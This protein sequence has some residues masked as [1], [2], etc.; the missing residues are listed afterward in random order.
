[1]MMRSISLATLGA[2]PFILISVISLII[3]VSWGPTKYHHTPSQVLRSVQPNPEVAKLWNDYSREWTTGTKPTSAHD[4]HSCSRTCVCT[5]GGLM[6][7]GRFCGFGY[8]GCDGVVPCDGVDACCQIHDAC[9]GSHG[10][11]DCNCTTA[12]TDCLACAMY[13]DES[14]RCD[15]RETAALNMMADIKFIVSKCYPKP[16]K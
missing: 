9:A 16:G 8:S 5:P 4:S 10:M 11:F 1:M 15:L 2:T 3:G 12:L 13:R 6:Y 14:W 7:Y